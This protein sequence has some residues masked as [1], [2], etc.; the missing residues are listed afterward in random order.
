[1]GSSRSVGYAARIPTSA[2]SSRLGSLPPRPRDT[3]TETAGRT[4]RVSVEGKAMISFHAYPV[5][6]QG[7]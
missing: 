4:H 2:R 7:H 3:R 6:T 5:S 1:M